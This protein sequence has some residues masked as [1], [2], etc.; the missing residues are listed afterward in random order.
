V[1]PAQAALLPQGGTFVDDNGNTHEGNIEAIAAEGITVGC[2]RAEDRFCPGALVH[3]DQTFL[4]R[5]FELPFT[6]TDFSG[7]DESSVHEANIKAIAA[8]AITE[9]CGAHRYRNGTGSAGYLLRL[10]G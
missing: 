10:E 3:R 9:G 4:A 2:N 5:A 7:D 1:A 8:A 6:A